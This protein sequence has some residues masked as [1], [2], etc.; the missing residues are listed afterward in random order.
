MWSHHQTVC[1]LVDA[2]IRFVSIIFHV[3]ARIKSREL[4][5]VSGNPPTQYQ[6]PTQIL[7]DIIF[8]LIGCSQNRLLN[9]SLSS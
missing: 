1:P 9:K 8:L 3:K 2:F 7:D 6:P 4:L 5:A